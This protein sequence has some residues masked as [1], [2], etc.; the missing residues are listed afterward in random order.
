MTESE[1]FLTRKQSHADLYFTRLDCPQDWVLH[2]NS[3][4]HVIDTPTLNWNDARTTCQNLGV[5]LAIIRSQDEN[6]FILDLIMKQQTIQEWAAWLGLYRKADNLFYWVDDTPL[7]D[8]YSAWA[9]GEPNN[10]ES[11]GEN[12]VHTYTRPLSLFGKW[13]DKLCN[14]DEANK[15]VAPVVLCQ[16]KRYI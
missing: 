4:Y 5:D 8:Q 7:A 2:G 3:C 9:D 11:N 13:N 16:K 6:N 1:K 10:Y 14:L 15:Y 12:C